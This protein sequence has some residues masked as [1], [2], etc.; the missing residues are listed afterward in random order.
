MNRL[1]SGRFVTFFELYID[2]PIRDR[3]GTVFR[4]IPDMLSGPYF[5]VIGYSGMS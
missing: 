5:H 4:I 3:T 2:V 1:L